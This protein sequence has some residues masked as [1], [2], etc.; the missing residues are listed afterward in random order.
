M[1]N[2]NIVNVTS[3]YG[4]LMGEALTTNLS[5]VIMTA[6][7]DVLLKVNSITVANWHASNDTAVT[8][9]INKIAFTPAGIAASQDNAAVFDLCQ[10]LIVP[11]TDQLQVLEQS[12]YLMTGDS[13]FA[14]ATVATAD[15]LVSYEVINDA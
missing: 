13:I 15:I 8:V 6:E 4:E 9:S 3:I 12:I 14:G 11:A 7:A 10:A 1:A 5:T 2:P